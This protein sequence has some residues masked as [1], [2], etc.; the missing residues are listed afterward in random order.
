MRNDHLEFTIPYEF[1]G[2]THAYTPDFL[3][4]LT[5]GTLLILEIKGEETEQDRAKHQAARRWVAAVNHWGKL[6]QWRFIV[7][8]DPQMLTSD[9]ERALDKIESP[10]G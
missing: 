6:G 4:R 8:K 7:C 1:E 2:V 5:D 3:V 10:T 9:L